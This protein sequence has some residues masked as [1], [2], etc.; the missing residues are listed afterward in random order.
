MP[1]PRMDAM[2]DDDTYA[3]EAAMTL[4]EIGYNVDR[5][6]ESVEE[7]ADLWATNAEDRLTVEVKSRVDDM[8]V[9]KDLHTSPGKIVTRDTPIERTDA[10]GRIVKKA[11]DQIVASQPDYPGLGVLWFR[12]APVLGISDAANQMKANLLGIRTVSFQR[13]KRFYFGTAY[14]TARTDFHR[15]PELNVAILE[16]NEEFQLIVNP[17]SPRIEHVRASLLFRYFNDRGAAFDLEQ[18]KPDEHNFVL[19]AE[20]DRADEAAVLEELARQNPGHR[21][22]FTQMHSFIGITV[23]PREDAE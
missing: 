20:I 5:I 2:S 16:Q 6:P 1:S 22:A 19:R 12:P 14:L 13:E 11:R 9:A 17:F 15:F 3:S 7:R 23:V 18:L 4:E 21:F 8:E 10:L